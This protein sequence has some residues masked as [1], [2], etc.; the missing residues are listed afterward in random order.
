MLCSVLLSI[1]GVS[2][3]LLSIHSLN[4]KNILQ[5]DA[6]FKNK[7]N[8]KTLK[9]ELLTL[10]KKVNKGLTETAEDRTT[11]AELF[12]KIE[13]F[14]TQNATLTN[15]NL[16]AVWSLEYTT[17]DSILDRGGAP[18]VGPIL[19]TIDAS[20]LKAENKEVRKYFVF[21]VPFKVTA[22]LT[23]SSPSRVWSCLQWL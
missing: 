7:S 13:S 15:K 10:S 12:N 21:N 4:I 1:L 5:F 2:I 23:P 3:T 11:I 20:N 9:N 16:N 19:Q 17:S 14:N 6:L 22:E 8:L 18:K